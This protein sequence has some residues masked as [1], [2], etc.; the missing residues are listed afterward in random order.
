MIMMIGLVFMTK[1]FMVARN[2][3]AAHEESEHVL[4]EASEESKLKGRLHGDIGVE[5]LV[6]LKTTI[7]IFRKS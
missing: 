5:R 6:K 1:I 3:L 4:C 7:I 2:E